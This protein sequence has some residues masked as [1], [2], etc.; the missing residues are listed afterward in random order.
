[1]GLTFGIASTLPPSPLQPWNTLFSL[2]KAN[3]S[4]T[5]LP[6][7]VSNLKSSCLSL[8]LQMPAAVFSFLFVCWR[9]EL[10]PPCLCA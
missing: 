3:I 9:Y 2:F 10:N 4:L 7:L 6:R 5:V 8:G 1:M